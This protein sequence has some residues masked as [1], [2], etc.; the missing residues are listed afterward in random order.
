MNK[1]SKITWNMQAAKF[2]FI[3]SFIFYFC[4]RTF[5]FIYLFIYFYLLFCLLRATPAAHGGSQAR[6]PIGAAVASLHHSHSNPS[7]ICNLHHSSW[8]CQI[9]NPLR[10]AKDQTRNLMVPRQICF[11]RAMTRT[12]DIVF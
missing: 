10:K 11:H 12:L 6:G 5:I 8:Q 1:V 2:H 4:L 9:L 3:Y 7:H